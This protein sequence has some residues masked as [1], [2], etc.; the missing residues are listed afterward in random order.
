MKKSGLLSL[1]FVF[2]ISTVFADT[3]PIQ[4]RRIDFG[5]YDEYAFL[6]YEKTNVLPKKD[7]VVSAV[8]IHVLGRARCD[9]KFVLKL[10]SEVKKMIVWDF[11]EWKPVLQGNLLSNGIGGKSA[12]HILEGRTYTIQGFYSTSGKSGYIRGIYRGESLPLGKYSLFVYIN[13]ELIKTI[14]FKV[15]VPPIE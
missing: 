11:G 9:Y 5:K 12:T 6:L 3:K 1:V 14:R 7:K 13:S 4:I 10:P 15:I 8:V 2:C